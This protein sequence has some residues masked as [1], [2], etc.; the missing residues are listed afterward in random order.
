MVNLSKRAVKIHE[1]LLEA[2]GNPTWRSYDDDQ[3]IRP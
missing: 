2:F 1:K 3:K